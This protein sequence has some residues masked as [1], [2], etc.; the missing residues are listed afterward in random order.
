[1]LAWRRLPHVNTPSQVPQRLRVH[2]LRPALPRHLPFRRHSDRLKRSMHSRT[3]TSSLLVLQLQLKRDILRL[4]ERRPR[5]RMPRRLAP[6]HSTARHAGSLV[7]HSPTLTRV[8]DRVGRR[9]QETHVPLNVSQPVFLISPELPKSIRTHSPSGPRITFSSFTSRWTARIRQEFVY[10][11]RRNT[12]RSRD[13]VENREHRP[14]GQDNS[15]P[16]QGEGRLD[17]LLPD[18][19]D[20]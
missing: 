15:E 8:Q 12:H 1:M 14:T 2:H 9:N 5:P 6:F 10:G 18:Q 17:R 3:G 19:K 16:R 4:G 20:R 7:Q 13:R 11:H